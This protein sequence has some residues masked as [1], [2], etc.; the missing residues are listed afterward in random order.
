MNIMMMSSSNK[1]Q[2][3]QRQIK[4]TFAHDFFFMG[5]FVCSMIMVH[6]CA[7]AFCCKTAPPHARVHTRSSS[8]SLLPRFSAVYT[9]ST[10]P[11]ISDVTIQPVS[12]KEDSAIYK[13]EG[14]F[15]QHNLNSSSLPCTCFLAAVQLALSTLA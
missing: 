5:F 10:G 2:F 3:V 4:S 11:C 1:L 6:C 13:G 7:S 15:K 9:P 8:L 14:D 12:E